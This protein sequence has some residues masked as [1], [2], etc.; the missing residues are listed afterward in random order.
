MPSCSLAA[1]SRRLQIEVVALGAVKHR[2]LVN[3]VTA[4]ARNLADMG[5]VGIGL[6]GGGLGR[7]LRIGPVAFR[8][9]RRVRL[10]RR[11]ALRVT[12]GTIQS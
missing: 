7:N 11:R 4:G 3:V 5:R 9:D 12:G 1:L 2:C 8:T 6:I 10:F